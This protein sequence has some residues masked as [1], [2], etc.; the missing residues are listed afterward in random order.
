MFNR[1]A[2]VREYRVGSSF[3]PIQRCTNSHLEGG[4]EEVERGGHHPRQPR[5]HGVGAVRDE[6]AP[7]A[8]AA[9]VSVLG[10]AEA[11]RVLQQRP[12]RPALRGQHLEVR[13]DARVYSHGGPN[14]R[15]MH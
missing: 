2:A 14:G 5:L 13:G 4:D 15:R 3:E 1:V 12:H 8:S 6:V 11:T 9:A 10:L 7:L